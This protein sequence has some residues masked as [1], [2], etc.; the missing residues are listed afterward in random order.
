MLPESIIG[1]KSQKKIWVG[2]SQVQNS[3]PART[4]FAAES[5][6]KI[7]IVLYTDLVICI[8]SINSYVRCIG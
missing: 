1:L 4:F 6:L 2:R 5:L 8:Y 3:V 7:Y